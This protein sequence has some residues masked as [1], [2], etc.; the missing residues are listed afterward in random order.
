M[1]PDLFWVAY[2]AMMA[3]IRTEKPQTIDA[4]FDVL[5]DMA[6]EPSSGEAFALE[7]GSLMAALEAAGWDV[8]GIEGDYL[9]EAK[10]PAGE[11]MHY[12]EG[13]LYRG[14]R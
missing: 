8:Y 6:P 12:V 7:G 2:D 11:W 14:R 5:R 10:S 1:S 4:L 9:F 3:R 13:D